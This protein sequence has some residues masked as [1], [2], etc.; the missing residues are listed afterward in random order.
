M[1]TQIH[2]LS[3]KISTQGFVL[4]LLLTASL[5]ILLAINGS[6]AQT[7]TGTLASLNTELPNGYVPTG[8]L[9]S[10]SNAKP[11]VALM[12]DGTYYIDNPTSAADPNFRVKNFSK[13]A[14]RPASEIPNT[15]KKA[16][17]PFQLKGDEYIARYRD[18]QDVMPMTAFKKVSAA[19]QYELYLAVSS[20]EPY[21]FYEEFWN[22]RISKTVFLTNNWK[23]VIF[24]DAQG[25]VTRVFK[26]AR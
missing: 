16:E 4:P 10:S 19:V 6:Y 22:D 21:A 17:V 25:E 1:K 9:T 3:P 20:G 7:A 18:F 13:I 12:D 2:T 26:K 15:Y 24:M 5:M 23:M 11:A 14:L 8:N